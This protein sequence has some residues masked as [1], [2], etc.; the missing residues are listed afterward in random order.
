MPTP[1]AA[2]DISAN[3]SWERTNTKVE[4][5]LINAILTPF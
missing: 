4:P 1:Q 2:K 5:S 3:R